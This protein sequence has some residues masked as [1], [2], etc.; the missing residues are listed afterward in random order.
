M[1]RRL[2][3]L[4]VFKGFLE[5]LTRLS[6]CKRASVAAI[7][8]DPSF[9]GVKAIGYNGW[10]HGFPSDSCIKTNDPCGCVHAEL[11]ACLKLN[12]PET[13]LIMLVTHTPCERCAQAIIQTRKIG[14]VLISEERYN[15]FVQP[16]GCKLLRE[17]G[18]Q[19]GVI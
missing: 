11:N 6:T 17:S 16:I 14:K 1:S 10:P 3:K 15:D 4:I 19:V 13:G 7:V 5:N 18:I 9:L 2:L 12:T 8:I